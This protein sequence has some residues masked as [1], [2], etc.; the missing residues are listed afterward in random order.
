VQEVM[1]RQSKD[2][3]G[4]VRAGKCEMELKR[5]GEGGHPEGGRGGVG[6]CDT[7]GW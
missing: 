3:G 7:L 5:K 1:Q 2:V 4:F 6:G